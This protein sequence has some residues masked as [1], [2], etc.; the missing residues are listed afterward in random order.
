MRTTIV[1]DD[2]LMEEL[3]RVEGD[4]SPSEAIRRAV[5][6]YLRRKR[7][8]RFLTLAGSKLIDLDW[9]KAEQQEIRKVKRHG[10]KR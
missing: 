1:I 9:R 10:R 6:E 8:D 5:E 2:S 3:M 7:M 4:V